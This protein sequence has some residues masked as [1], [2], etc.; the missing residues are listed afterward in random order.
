[1]LREKAHFFNRLSQLIDI[2]IINLSFFAVHFLFDYERLIN[3]GIPFS[4]FV[5]FVLYVVFWIIAADLNHVYESR[6]MVS[7]PKELNRLIKSSLL[8]LVLCLVLARLVD[9]ELV[10]HLFVVF[11]SL[12]S[13]ILIT[14]QHVLTRLVLEKFRR[15]GRN[16]HYCLIIGNGLAANVFLEQVR[17]N[18]QLGYRVIGYLASQEGDIDIPYLGALNNLESV[19]SHQVVDLVI[20]TTP[21]KDEAVNECLKLIEIEGKSILLLSDDMLE[22]HQ[23]DEYSLMDFGGLSLFKIDTI[24]RNYWHEIL[25]AFFDVVA[26]IM[27]V[28]L[29][30]P[31]MLTVAIAIKATSRGPVFFVQNRVGMNG[32]IF[33]M[34]KFRSMVQNADAM[35]E[36]LASQNE[37]SGP[38]FKIKND[39]RVTPVGRFI[40]KTSLDE[41]PQFFNVIKRD[42]SLVGPRPPLPKEVDMYNPNHR[43]RLS[44][45]PGITCIWQISGRNSVDFNQWMDLDAEYIDNWSIWLDFKILLKT[46]PVVLLRKGAS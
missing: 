18:P 14:V 32:R 7:L 21:R 44:V 41:L 31:L 46:I 30:S 22:S 11:F 24:H 40:R 37:M 43:K 16:I 45:R 13:S 35:K 6:R 5:A 20:I 15:A 39:P 36:S 12:T 38:V 9:T 42:M 2:L 23:A 19:L 33:K 25:K 8:A 27:A 34:Y 26:S 29:L 28:I 3:F 4:L 10:N 17:K 1:M